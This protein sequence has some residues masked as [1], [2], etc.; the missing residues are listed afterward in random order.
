MPPQCPTESTIQDL[1][2]WLKTEPVLDVR[3]TKHD[4]IALINPLNILSLIY[5]I[6]IQMLLIIAT[7][8][9]MYLDNKKCIDTRTF[10]RPKKRSARM[11]F[12]S[13]FEGLPPSTTDIKKL[14]NTDV[15]R[16]EDVGC[17]SLFIFLL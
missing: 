16:I 10:T 12:E 4:N 17:L 3:S 9:N 11:S 15:T 5:N 13:I 14:Q 2:A 1:Y 6:I 8:F 7:K